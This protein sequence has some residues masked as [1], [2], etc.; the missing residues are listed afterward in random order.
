MSWKIDSHIP[1]QAWLVKFT[2]VPPNRD[3]NIT[4][5]QQ[6]SDINLSFAKLI[7]SRTPVTKTCESL[8]IGRGTYYDKLEFL[9]RRCLEFLE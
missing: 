2:N 8:G 3:K 4:Y 7:L 6:R 5:H 9:Y 1:S